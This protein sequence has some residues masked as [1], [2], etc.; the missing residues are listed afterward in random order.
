[1]YQAQVLKDPEGHEGQRGEL[2]TRQQHLGVEAVER[3][4]QQ[5]HARGDADGLLEEGTVVAAQ[6]GPVL[7]VNELSQ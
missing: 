2:A 6:A 3:V 1:M 4:G 5:R 7:E